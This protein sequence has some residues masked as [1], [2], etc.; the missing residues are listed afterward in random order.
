MR[1]VLGLALAPL[2]VAG[3][4]Y[5]AARERMVREDIEARG[6]RDPGVLRAMRTTPRHLFVPPGAR[7]QA[8]EDHP[9]PIG[10]GA[11]ISQPY[12]VAWMTELL[13][14]RKT[15]RVLEIGT[16]S[17]YQSAVLSPLVKHVY[18]VE[19]VPELAQSAAETLKR[20]GYENVTVRQGDGYKGWPE[21][22]PFDRILLTAA[23]A[24]IP[25]A[26]IDQLAPGGRLVAPVGDSPFSQ[27]LIVLEKRPD[28]S[29][30]RRSVGGVMFVP[31]VTK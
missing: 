1:L 23:P 24:R 17:G 18:T 25:Q 21:H 20:L 26:L 2:L 29:I 19:I 14:P 9:L 27:D 5:G 11:T 6:V 13:Q 12:I 28:G 22:A 30:R 3:D 16:G 7:A 31:M 4:P 10:H 8:Y 15:S